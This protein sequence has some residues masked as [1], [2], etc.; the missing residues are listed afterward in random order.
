MKK[1]LLTMFV[2]VC[3]FSSTAFSQLIFQEG[4]TSYTAG[5]LAGQGGWIHSGSGTD[6]PAV[7]SASPLAYTNYVDQ[8]GNYMNFAT[9]SATAGRLYKD[10]SDTTTQISATGTTVYVS[11]LLNLTTTYA[12]TATAHQYFLSLGQ[13]NGST[14]GYVGKFYANNVSASTYHLGVTNNA[15]SATLVKYAA[16][17]LNTGQTYFIVMRYNIYNTVALR[18]SNTVQMWI[19]PAGT[20]EPDTTVA[21]VSYPSVDSTYSQVSIGSFLWHNRGALS[22][23]GTIDGIRVAKDASSSA[24]AWGYLNP[25]LPVELTSFTATASKNAVNLRWST[26]TE[27]NNTGFQVERSGNGTGW[28]TLT[29]VKGGGNSNSTKSYSYTDNSITKTGKYYYRLRQLDVDGSFKYSGTTEVNFVAPAVFTLN[30]NYPNP[31]NPTTMISYSI[32]AGSN[33]KLSVYNAIGKVVSV[34]E[35]GF[36]EAGLYNVSFN[37]SNLPSGLYFY[38]IEAGQFS[39]TRKMMLVK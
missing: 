21:D 15:T 24:T 10:F 18:K 14:V 26:A 32:P 19:N 39:S 16:A 27:L 31:F 30:Q 25:I 28:T 4:F 11:F 9:N 36:K 17:T 13:S 34:L 8:G 7:A 20:S 3:L 38:K 2:G 35:N 33:V 5:A 22:P 23:L 6:A 12:Q 1:A 29:F 37:A